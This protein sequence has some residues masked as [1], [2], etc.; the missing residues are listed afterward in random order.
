MNGRTR[1]DSPIPELAKKPRFRQMLRLVVVLKP[2]IDIPYIIAG[3]VF[4]SGQL[5]RL[6]L[7]VDPAKLNHGEEFGKLDYVDLFQI[8]ICGLALLLPCGHY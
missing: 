4:F 3:Q 2:D 8:D 1:A 7:Q 6:T 5:C